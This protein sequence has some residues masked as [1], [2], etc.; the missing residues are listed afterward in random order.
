MATKDLNI[1]YYIKDLIDIGVTSLKIEGRMRSLY[2]LATVVGTYRK[3][4]DAIYENNLT[5]ELMKKSEEVLSRVANREV[6]TQYLLKEADM[7]DQYYT[8]RSEVSN[9]D[10]LGEVIEY[11]NNLIKIYERNYFKIGDRVELFTPNG[12]IVEFVVQKLYDEDMNE[13]GVANHP[14]YIYYIGLDTNTEIDR[15]SM[16]RLMERRDDNE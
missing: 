11:E 9:Q 4:I 15:Y 10:Y 14:D 12:D 13:V 6:S 1:S 5:D 16:I 8:G 2:Y 7:N 3:I